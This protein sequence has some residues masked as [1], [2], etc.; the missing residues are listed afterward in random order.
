MACGKGQNVIGINLEV[1]T[2]NLHT[3]LGASAKAESGNALASLPPPS[4]VLSAFRQ[5]AARSPRMTRFSQYVIQS[6]RLLFWST[7]AFFA[8]AGATV[9]AIDASHAPAVPKI[10]DA[11][12]QIVLRPPARMV[13]R[14]LPQPIAARSATAEA[15]DRM[16]QE[17]RCLSE[18]LY[19]EARG[20][21]EEGQAG[22]AEVIFHRLASGRHGGTICAVIYEGANQTFCQFTFAC[23]GSLDRTRAA[24]A[25]RA[26]QVLAARIM[27][28]QVQ[29]PPSLDG[30]T[31]YHTTAVRPTWA[32]QMQ[33]LAQIGNHIFY[34]APGARAA[35]TSLRG[36]QL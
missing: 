19:F 17:H 11:E 30:A 16:T 36:S 28:G 9:A 4:A 6:R 1:F 8:T 10:P 15:M 33:R 34:R 24:D 14:A 32:P 20:E 22:V 7:M 21:S 5:P 27:T 29:A 3:K 13:K 26:A 2:S 25:W 31:H 18:V 12:M 35:V 23:D